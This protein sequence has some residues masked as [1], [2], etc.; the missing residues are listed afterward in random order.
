MM[1]AAD[2]SKCDLTGQAGR[3]RLLVTYNSLVTGDRHAGT[4]AGVSKPCDFFI[5][6]IQV[7]KSEIK[8]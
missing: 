1:W 3:H 7:E 8:A 5:A 4:G 2:T 6:N